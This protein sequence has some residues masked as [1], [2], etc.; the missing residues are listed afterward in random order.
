MAHIDITI[1]GQQYKI[2]CPDGEQEHL[3]EAVEQVDK[4]L[5]EL[6][7][8]GRTLRNEQLIVMTALN[9]RHQLNTIKAENQARTE[10]LNQRILQLQNAISG[11]LDK[12]T[13]NEALME[14]GDK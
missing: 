7:T 5:K 10:Q 6:K 1:L 9:Y 8:S 13:Q 11:V 14:D 3:L 4:H 2:G 12:T